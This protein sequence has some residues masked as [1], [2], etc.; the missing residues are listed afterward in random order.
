M[1][2][3]PH[4]AVGKSNKHCAPAPLGCPDEN[5]SQW[6][7]ERERP[8]PRGQ[9]RNAADPR[10]ACGPHAAKN[11]GVTFDSPITFQSASK[12]LVF[13]PAESA[14]QSKSVFSY[15]RLRF[16]EHQGERPFPPA[17]S[18]ICQGET[19]DR[20]GWLLETS[21]CAGTPAPQTRAVQGSAAPAEA[22]DSA[23][24]GRSTDTGPQAARH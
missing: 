17:V 14:N 4:T 11:P 2:Q 6:G 5:L 10:T 8:Q 3:K 23:G 15:S 22:Q 24:E 9:V 16:P 20:K 21:A 12:S 19:P 18:C 1:R 13:T 7:R